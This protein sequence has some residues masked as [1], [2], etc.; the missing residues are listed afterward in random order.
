MKIDEDN[1]TFMTNPALM[2]HYEEHRKMSEAEL[3]Q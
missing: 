1:L 2:N 3:N